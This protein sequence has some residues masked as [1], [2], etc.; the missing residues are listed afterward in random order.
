MSQTV[1]NAASKPESAGSGPGID[2]HPPGL[3]I[4]FATEMWERY[5]FYTI[6]AVMTLYLQD[7]TQGF[8]WTK[9]QAT[10]LWANNLMF[11]YLT[12]FVGGWIAD[13]FIGYRRS[14]LIG[15][16]VF[17]AGYLLLGMG[18]IATFYV[19]LA[20][21]YVG[22][23]F[24]KPNISTMV[25]NLYP[26]GSPL[27][28]SAYNIFYMGINVGAFA[29]AARRRGP[30]AEIWLPGRVLRGGDR[31]GPGHGH[32]RDLLSV[33]GRRRAQ[34]AVG[35]S[36]ADGAGR[37]H[38]ARPGEDGRSTMCRTWKRIGALV[39]IYRDR[40]RVLDGLPPE[41]QHDDLL[42]QR[43]HR[44]EGLEGHADPDPDLHP[45]PDRR[46]ERL[47]RDLQRHQPILD[48]R[49]VD[50]AGPVLE[51]LDRKG[52]EPST[53]TKIA[54]GMFLTCVA[55]LI[56]GRS[57]GVDGRRHRPRL[58]PGGSIGAPILVISLGELMLSP[59]GLSLVSKSRRPICGG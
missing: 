17:V 52:L 6:L 44:L 37:G 29:G 30:A 33:H 10:R 46:L 26:P 4:L 54:L 39:V 27:R 16:A 13:R 14:I 3:Y 1:A 24:F 50:S 36:S 22:N 57:G 49:P 41:R 23:G 45:E 59:M 43:Q 42:G 51:W 55:F 5:G 31:H 34:A 11:V 18:S 9:D 48:R 2:R 32:L 25:G 35:R 8:G 56:S 38:L 58:D 21:I 28:D 20:L 40:H 47:G 15:G 12:P 19:A 53:P 7:Q